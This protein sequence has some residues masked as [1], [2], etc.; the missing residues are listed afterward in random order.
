MDLT[1]EQIAGTRSAGQNP[2]PKSAVSHA[3]RQATTMAA[4]VRAAV[5]A[6]DPGDT[7]SSDRS[8]EPSPEAPPAPERFENGHNNNH[9]LRTPARQALTFA[10]DGPGSPFRLEAPSPYSP[11]P[12]SLLSGDDNGSSRRRAKSSARRPYSTVRRPTR[13]P[14][15][16]VSL[17]R[18]HDLTMS[19]TFESE[20]SMEEQLQQ[21]TSVLTAPSPVLNIPT[22]TS[23][24]SRSSTQLLPAVL[25]LKKQL[26][27]SH[28]S[29]FLMQEENKALG[30]EIDRLSAEYASYKADAEKEMSE[31]QSSQAKLRASEA[32]LAGEKK[33][34]EAKQTS[35]FKQLESLRQLEAELEQTKVVKTSLEKRVESL[36]TAQTKADSKLIAVEQGNKRLEEELAAAKA[37][38]MDAGKEREHLEKVREELHAQLLDVRTKHKTSSGDSSARIKS[39]EKEVTRIRSEKEAAKAAQQLEIDRLTAVLRETERKLAK[40]SNESTETTAVLQEKVARLDALCKD[41][42]NKNGALR[43]EKMALRREV[44]QLKEQLQQRT[45]QASQ[46]PPTS[47][48]GCQTATERV[49]SSVQTDTPMSTATVP[50]YLD[51]GRMNGNQQSITDRLG[52]I[53]DAAERATFLQDYRREVS[54][55]KADHERQVHELEES[56][57]ATLRKIVSDAKEELH[58]QTKEYKRRVKADYETKIAALERKHQEDLARVGLEVYRCLRFAGWFTHFLFCLTDSPRD[59]SQCCDDQ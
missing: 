39:L 4:V 48:I 45:R 34:L 36:E 33:A 37:S 20:E 16:E 7:D 17:L 21:L 32:R 51:T 3:Q 8:P 25:D 13:P 50:T 30:S 9:H 56:H 49:D 41:S 29:L 43:A 11:L 19:R 40:A 55:L 35:L 18:A 54:R 31:A 6:E 24:R 28:Q 42:S 47:E 22:P 10:K 52:R 58:S 1:R 2:I 15:Q 53:R 27:E 23:V 46:R 5:P 44:T 57:D 14:L 38:I 26:V 59:G 12:P